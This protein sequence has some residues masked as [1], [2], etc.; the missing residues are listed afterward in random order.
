MFGRLVAYAVAGHHAGLADFGEL[1][2]RVQDK[3][4]ADYAGWRGPAGE[5]PQIGDFAPPSWFRGNAHKGFSEAFLTRMLF[6]CLVDA[7]FLATEDF[8]DRVERRESARRG[9]A[10]RGSLQDRL[11]RHLDRKQL[12][13][14]PTPLNQLRAE[15]LAHAVDKATLDPGPFTL[16][17]QTRWP[18]SPAPAGGGLVKTE[19]FGRYDRSDQ[20]EAFDQVIQSWDT[21]NTI[22]QWSDYSVC[23]S[24]GVKD[25][26]IYLL[27]LFRQRLIY[28]DL[29]RAVI[30][31]ARLHQPTSILIED[32][33]SG[34]Q[35]IQD[36]Q[37]DGLARI[38]PC[39][40]SADKR[41]RMSSVTAVIEN[42]LVLIPRE[43]HWLQDYLHELALFPNGRYD[44]QVD[45]TSQAL[46]WIGNPGMSSW[47]LLQ[48]M[49]RQRDG[50]SPSGGAQLRERTWALGSM[51]WAAELAALND[52]A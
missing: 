41:M 22:Q 39:K 30:D 17:G 20:P 34:T 37:R 11:A 35:L 9:F 10:D 7:D 33:A 16:T 50:L 49:Q 21:A 43:A 24:W 18:V 38:Q 19:W 23:T 46:G 1:G 32:R 15:V 8:Y 42:G 31:Q 14:K 12:D 45:S 26:R 36:L 29:K 52:A 47:G 48:L 3:A 5:L 4:L 51:E 44:D 27:G 28:P 13:A 25:K 40:P 6:S 2:R